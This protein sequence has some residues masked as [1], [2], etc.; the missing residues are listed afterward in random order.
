MSKSSKKSRLQAIPKPKVQK[1]PQKQ[2]KQQ[3]P[4]QPPQ[5][6]PINLCKQNLCP[7][8]NQNYIQAFRIYTPPD[9]AWP[10]QVEQDIA[11]M[12]VLI[13]VKCGQE[14]RS[15]QELLA[16]RIEAVVKETKKE[17][18]NEDINNREEEIRENNIS[19]NVDESSQESG[20]NSDSDR[21]IEN[22]E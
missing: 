12:R 1:M 18:L 21:S 2:Q 5:S 22:E 7:C 6:I 16:K 20:E 15:G 8:G 17:K 10:M 14:L 13:C 11:T 9:R 4:E 19:K 3:I